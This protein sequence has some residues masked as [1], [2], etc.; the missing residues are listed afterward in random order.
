[1]LKTEIDYK[2]KKISQFPI[3]KYYKAN[4]KVRFTYT[5]EYHKIR[6][7][8]G[9]VLLPDIAMDRLVFQY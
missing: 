4:H 7:V 1:M 2:N 8:H 6:P 5:I 3:E 9:Q